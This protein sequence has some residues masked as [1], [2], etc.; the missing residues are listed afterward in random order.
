MNAKQVKY[1][2]LDAMWSFLQMGSQEFTAEDA[3]LLAE[4]CEQLKTA[5]MQKTAGQRKD[6]PKDVDFAELDAITNN[7]VIG[8]MSLWLSGKLEELE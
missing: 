6:K 3:R 7:I 8:T 4:S 5:M 1:D 2:A